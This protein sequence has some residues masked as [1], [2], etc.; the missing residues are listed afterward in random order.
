M[1]FLSYCVTLSN[2]NVGEE[3]IQANIGCCLMVVDWL[4][5]MLFWLEIRCSGPPDFHYSDPVEM[6]C[7]C[8]NMRL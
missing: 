5:G 6:K 3:V 7:V 1:L 8:Y 4:S 2:T